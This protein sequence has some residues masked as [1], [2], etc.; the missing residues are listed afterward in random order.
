MIEL[1]TRINKAGVVLEVVDGKLKVFSSKDQLDRD[2]LAEIKANKEQLTEYL[3][4]GKAVNI[5]MKK[6]SEI[7]P[8][9]PAKSYLLSNAQQRLWIACQTEA[10]SLAYNIPNYI[11]L[12]GSY[13]LK[14]FEKAIY[15]VIDRHEVLR[16][17]F[18]EDKAGEIRQFILS[19]T[20]LDFKIDHQD[21]SQSKDAEAAVNSYL[22]FDSERPF[23]LDKGPLLR[24]ALLQL[25]DDQTIF[26]YNL[27]HIISDGWSMDVLARDV[28]RYYDAYDQG[29]ELPEPL[30]IQYKDYATWQRAEL[31]KLQFEKD[32]N[33]WLD[34]F[35]DFA[36]S[37]DLPAFKRRPPVRTYNGRKL[38]LHLSK[39]LIGPLRD[40]SIEKGGSLFTGLLAVWKILFYRYS[41]ERNIT[42]GNPV[43]GRGHADLEDQIGF[44]VN[45][46]ALRNEIDP[47]K[48]FEEWFDQLK[49][50]TLEAYAHQHYPYDKLLEDLN[51]VR[52]TSRNP[53]FDVK[54]DYHGAVKQGLGL[55]P[56]D[57]IVDFGSCLCKFDLEID[58]SEYLDGVDLLIKY[59]TDLYEPEM[60]EGLVRHF[61][62]LLESI[63][64]NAHLRIDQINFLNE[65]EQKELLEEF[66][67]TKVLQE[68]ERTVLD[69]F[70]NQVNGTPESVAVE[71]ENRFLSY[72]DLDEKS[73]QFA[74]YLVQKCS[75]PQ[76]AFVG[77]HLD[78]SDLYLIS[79]IGIFKAGAVFIPIDK[80]YPLS[81]KQHIIQDA[82]LHTII[83][84]QTDVDELDCH[85]GSFVL[86]DADQ[87]WNTYPTD[88]NDLAK[89]NELAYLIY[90]SGST[91]KPKGVMI[92]H[93]SLYNY[94]VWS[95]GYYFNRTLSN[96]DFGWFT[97]PA[98]DLTLTSL[99][100]PL[101]GGGK[102]TIFDSDRHVLDTLEA[103]ANSGLSCIKLTPAHVSLLSQLNLDNFNIELAIVGG[104]ELKK[105]HIETLRRLNSN[106][107][108][109][110]E[111]GPTEATIGCIVHEVGF[112]GVQ[113]IYIGKPI[114]NTSIYILDE[115][116]QLA[117]I[118]AP[119]EIY[120]GGAGLGRGYHNQPLLTDAKFI[121]NP[122]NQGER[123][124]QTGDVGCW[125]RDGNIIF[126][127]RTDFQVKIRGYR[128]EL[129]EIESILNALNNIEQAVVIAKE[130]NTG[131]KQL[132]A[133]ILSKELV[134]ENSLKEGLM[135]VLE[136]ELPDYMIPKIYVPLQE[137]PLTQNGKI[138]RQALPTPKGNFRTNKEYI[139]PQSKI[140]IQLANIW[141]EVLG[142]EQV[143]ML[144]DFFEL[145][146]HSLNVIKLVNR[147]N[148]VYQKKISINDIFAN[149]ELADQAKLIDK[150]FDLSYE[151]IP[152]AKEG[153]SYPV[154]NAQLRIWLTSQE[155][156]GAVAYN[157]PGSI[158]LNDNYDLDHFQKA[159][160]A[161]IDRH[162]ILRTV[163]KLNE[164]GLLRQYILS[165]EDLSFKIDIQDYRG[166]EE[167]ESLVKAYISK[168][169]YQAFDFEQGP[170]LRVSLLRLTDKRFIFYYNMH[171]IISDGWSMNV[172]A[173]DVLALYKSFES[174]GT[175][176]LNPLRIQYKDFATWQLDLLS[177]K[178]SDIHKNY[179]IAKF[180]E[181]V[182]PLD[183]PTQKRRPQHKTYYGRS[184]GVTITQDTVSGLRKFSE[185]EGGS[186]FI[187][188]L[189]GLKILLYRYT[190]ETD[191]TVGNSAAGRN[192]T[193]LEQQI[194]FYVNLL[195]LR[196]HID[197]KQS[198]QTLY[199][200]IKFS[201]F[202]ALEHQLYPYDQLLEVLNFERDLSRNPLF[203]IVVNYHGT[204]ESFLK[205]ETAINWEDGENDMVK[206]D[207]DLHFYE[208]GEELKLVVNYNKDV[209]EQSMITQLLQH[210]KALLSQ[211]IN[212][213]NESIGQLDYLSIDEKKVLLE[214]FNRN[215][216]KN[217]KAETVINLFEEQ[218]DQSPSANAILYGNKMINYGD[219]EEQVNR[220]ANYLKLE[221][222][223]KPGSY[224]G[225]HLDRSE[226]YPIVLLGILKAGGAFVPIDKEYPI[227]RK[228]YII[229]HAHIHLIVVNARDKELITHHKG[230][231][232]VLD[233]LP[234]LSDYKP[235]RP[236]GVDP[237]A[238]AYII[239]TSGSTGNPKG[240]VIQHHALYNYLNW[241]KAFY[242][243]HE[244]KN[245]NFGFFT[246]PSFDLTIT[247]LFLPLVS[248]GQ[249]EIL[250]KELNVLDALEH[251]FQGGNAGI[252]LTP[253]HIS[254]L[255]DSK[256][257]QTDLELAIVGGEALK[258]DQV[259]ILRRFNPKIKIYNEY[260]PTE[261]TVG[262]VVSEVDDPLTSIYIGKPID[263][264][265]IFILDEFQQLVPLGVIGEIYIGGMGLA[266]GYLNETELT[267]AKFIPHPFKDGERVYRTGDLACWMPDGQLDY[268][269]RIDFQ[270][271]IRGYRIEI[272]E[273][274][275]KLNELE[276][277]RQAV[278]LAKPDTKGVKH[279][280]AYIVCNT[281]PD[282]QEIKATLIQN[283]PPYMVPTHYVEIDRLKLTAN[284]K[285]DR[286]TLLNLEGPVVTTPFVSPTTAIE[287]Q[288]V[289][290]WEEVLGMEKIGLKHNFFEL[291]GHSLKALRL[292]GLY[293]RDFN[294]QVSIRDIFTHPVL[295]S[296]INLLDLSNTT[297]Y[298]R[299]P[300]APK[301][302][303]YP[304][305]SAQYRVWLMNQMERQSTAYNLFDFVELDGT[306]DLNSFQSAIQQLII[307][308]EILRTF[309]IQ[310]ESG[311]PRQQIIP[312]DSLSF[313]VD[314]IDYQQEKTPEEKAQ[315][316]MSNDAEQAFDLTQG[317]LLRAALIR[318]SAD[319]TIFYFNMHHIIGDEWSLDILANDVMQLYQA[320]VQNKKSS[321][322]P[323]HIQYKDYSLWQ[324]NQQA[325]YTQN[326][327]PFWTNRLNKTIPALDLPLQKTRPK[328]KTANGRSIGLHLPSKVTRRLH[329]FLARNDSSI[330]LGILAVWKV[331]LYHYTGEEEIT[332]GTPVANRDHPDLD[333]QIGCY[334]NNLVLNKRVDPQQDFESFFDELKNEV[335]E[336]FEHKAYPFEKL[337][338][339]LS[340]QGD[341]SRSPLFDLYINNHGHSVKG[342]GLNESE[343][344]QDLGNNTI[345]FDVELH[346]VTHDEGID[347]MINYNRDL[348]DQ[349]I[350]EN[351]LRHFRQLLE[352]LLDNPTEKIGMVQFLSKLEQDQI[353]RGFNAKQNRVMV[354]ETVIELFTKTSE[355]TPGAI[356]LQLGNQT[357]TYEALGTKS[358]QFANYLIKECGVKKGDF[359][360][361]HLETTSLYIISVLGILKAGAVYVP[362]DKAYPAKR[363]EYIIQDTT[364]STLICDADGVSELD[365]HQGNF[366]NVEED[367]KLD[368]F[369]TEVSFSPDPE[370]LAYIIYTSGSTGNPKGVMIE[371]RSLW[372]YLSWGR[373]YY[374]Q[375]GLKN[376][377]FGLFTS[378]SFD[379][380]LTSILLPL[381]SGGK[382]RLFESSLH[383]AEVLETYLQSDMSCIKLTPAHISILDNIGISSSP[384]ELA[385]VGG[386][387]LKWSH[388]DTLRRFNPNMRI[389]NEY[390]PTEATIGCIVY[391]VGDETSPKVYIGKP[392]QNTNIYILNAQKQAVPLGVV[393]E[394]YI[395]G[396]GVGRGY[397]N[398]SALSE[399]KFVENPFQTGERLYRSGDLGCWLPDGNIDFKGRGDH[400]V[401]I[402]GY[403]IE[404]EEIE[405]IL[406]GLRN[407]EQAIVIA[408]ADNLGEKRL[409]AYIVSK[410][411]VDATSLKEGLMLV[412]E[413][414]L[415]DYMIPQIYVLI[416]EIPLTTN[417]KIDRKALPLPNDQ[418]YRKQ[419]YI[420]PSTEI[421]WALAEIWQEILSIEQVGIL[422]NFFE[423]GGDSIRLMNLN[424][425]IQ[426]KYHIKVSLRDF[427]NMPTIKELAQ[428]IDVLTVA[429]T[430]KIKRENTIKI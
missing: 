30:R 274:E 217:W 157:M 246:S 428:F 424:L 212:A 185:E 49:K 316:Y 301:A 368:T 315:F 210:Y 109:F 38:G 421:E 406:N 418:A 184:L 401:K 367:L 427:F 206:F 236:K 372:N 224:V 178:G 305:S 19:T 351:H 357:W 257:E 370:D 15:G 117:P 93:Q 407:I 199:N 259:Q 173:K 57:G 349:I 95:K 430:Q 413:E 131:E 327:K 317:P 77:V 151:E 207:L 205:T 133:Y 97:S 244:I 51:V 268:K 295:E 100:L 262:C 18:K 40:F 379:L 112:D 276:S 248:G 75:V 58:P 326:H 303:D 128:I 39:E 302:A 182:P 364:M 402:K 228:Q 66:N 27:H 399:A 172:L 31:E 380:T 215:K 177:R 125:Q 300:K 275:T 165:S 410:E 103:Y 76:G 73:N 296:H 318:L 162:E 252:K 121:E 170:L 333:N 32:R 45:T 426:N 256:I 42:I 166:Q 411:F 8:C 141:Q 140:E 114:R 314:V 64:K 414:E 181:E 189:T 403:R 258:A 22:K 332:I 63:L 416:E 53:L 122:F 84:Q 232:L 280:I 293:K 104:E 143:G 136:E 369:N 196:N 334:L 194:G 33:Y 281:P 17:V 169:V 25:P 129:E 36:N 323:L 340:I 137:F 163:F 29:K 420:P 331:L 415:P 395:G 70:A 321:L 83:C 381:V 238:D 142:V 132:I 239:Y 2:L 61:K 269:G 298:V 123:I 341:P 74:N 390:G 251:Y 200:Q 343:A 130:D 221:F 86:T 115:G 183:L 118:G 284:G 392:I 102:L 21:F 346:L 345:K 113:P 43:A 356:A 198:F 54:I 167:A 28:M 119:G 273:I 190:G 139:T 398:Q 384:I 135:L 265:S 175:S 91:G 225:V 48:S 101:V 312:V 263:N 361:V 67:D 209:Y 342:F 412:L 396:Q 16:T 55:K 52:D 92:E 309:F 155:K 247:S 9:P 288:L 366:V 156:E 72:K 26:Y 386:E 149:P 277:I 291:G 124:Y 353:V 240:V 120:I 266:K 389:I 282:Y 237:T 378:P 319:R 271:K 158:D 358:G 6:Y 376:R 289:T 174:G 60:I 214:G 254:L 429:Q 325:Q 202:E 47:T 283:L 147:Y 188:F 105:T 79:L 106:M 23:H 171:H 35:K 425:R 191:I 222:G 41:G 329:E 338:E 161:V 400:Q 408:K 186:I 37:F 213:P 285:V 179:W 261:A 233:L 419:K 187:G 148:K 373:D 359:V 347:L 404:L 286:K 138:D 219:L 242:F 335:F 292:I 20:E 382:L 350:I 231:I 110:N 180:K 144:D 89:S 195:A 208:V 310:N 96:C 423:L 297:E 50:S 107:Y 5:Q 10:G 339:D 299:I 99:L 391:E 126:K 230:K 243:N 355:K 150:S 197:P 145:G 354:P 352:R 69:L 330:F 360:G 203:D 153:S 218:V 348:Y 192:H 168:D 260:G 264:V 11:K 234:D 108:I 278:V 363:K 235:R 146:G 204:T 328:W 220:I 7:P 377:D 159:I 245:R 78:R 176:D 56:T 1:L 164:S 313:T 14:S 255:E 308:H 383:V 306:F 371:H 253:T 397:L 3:E 320:N 34:Q 227:H 211:L 13:D 87:K 226:L 68:G 65:K 46:L 249:L 267:E 160:Y 154:S 385:I 388:V 229:S 81:R 152:I 193:D 94:L 365:Y 394:I 201:T 250:N 307:R 362:I 44:Y 324:I 393:G 62:S 24:A 216:D 85:Q 12:D 127:G 375:A 287:K 304:L 279:L 82:N 322:V 241:A 374:Y 88:W 98:F 417:G 387:E 294:K 344:L 134:D 337:L 336:A 59:N 90:T 272:E 311:I 111:Y 116:K 223:I 290:L 405:K 409:I 71:F 80:A 4:R 422:D 270:V